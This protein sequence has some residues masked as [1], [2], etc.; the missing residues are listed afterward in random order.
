MAYSDQRD[1]IR[2]EYGHNLQL[3][4]YGLSDYLFLVSPVSISSVL[5]SIDHSKTWTEIEANKLSNDFFQQRFP[6]NYGSFFN[7]ERYII[8]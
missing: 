7:S 1:Y 2:H 6:T 5:F 8:K 4:L 3:Q